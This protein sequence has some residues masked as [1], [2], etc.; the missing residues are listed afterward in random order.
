M[1]VTGLCGGIGA[2]KSTVAGLFSGH[3]AEV[4]DVDQLGR[5]VIEPGGR[6]YAAVIDLFGRE[7][8]VDGSE[9]EAHPID[10]A[11]LASIVFGDPAELAR[12]E[13]VSHPAI[14]AELDML[15]D[16]AAAD[17]H[18]W[19]V[20]DMAILVESKLGQDLP[21]GRGYD[22]VVVVE[23]PVEVRVERLVETRGMDPADAANRI[24]SQ[25]DDATRRAVAD[26]VLS[27]DGDL[28][29]LGIEVAKVLPQL[30][31]DRQPKAV[32]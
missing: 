31:D 1:R 26:V 19:V 23:A 11:K 12:L 25:T 32:D 16:Q 24:A 10:R 3:G 18:R 21:S 15:L 29:A 20:L 30:A 27:N 28:V 4:I 8:L 2:G 6:A 13:A 5:T 7:I 22:T 17:G 14:N 9:D